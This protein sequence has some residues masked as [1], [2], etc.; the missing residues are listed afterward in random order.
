MRLSIFY[1]GGT[2]FQHK[3]CHKVTWISS[4]HETQNQIDH[5][6]VSRRF[7]KSL[8]DVGNKRGIGSDHHLIVAKFKI[9]IKAKQNKYEKT[10]RRYDVA[11]LRNKEM[12][13]EFNLRLRNRFS[14]LTEETTD[15][16]K[17]KS[18]KVKDVHAK[19]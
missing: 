12:G 19:I 4:D 18:D 17:V 11:E 2:V 13:E 14:N 16:V 7:R 9:K 15:S 5:I 6:I 10:D 3:N 8:E 1:I